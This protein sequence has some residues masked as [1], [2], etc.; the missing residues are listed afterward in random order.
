[1]SASV[2]PGLPWKLVQLSQPI[3]GLRPT[4]ASNPSARSVSPPSAG[5]A[6]QA[7]RSA[8]SAARPVVAPH[9]GRCIDMVFSLVYRAIGDD[10][11]AGNRAVVS[12]QSCGGGPMGRFSAPH[13]EAC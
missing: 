11:G 12:A 7:T 6:E 9:S 4:P 1:M 3:G 13:D 10:Y 2:G 8:Q 5:G